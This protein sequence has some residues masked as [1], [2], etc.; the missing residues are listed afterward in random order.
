MNTVPCVLCCDCLCKVFTHADDAPFETS[1]FRACVATGFPSILRIQSDAPSSPSALCVLHLQHLTASSFSLNLPHT[2]HCKWQYLWKIRQRWW[3]RLLSC[4][5]HLQARERGYL[6]IRFSILSVAKRQLV[7][8]GLTL[9]FYLKCNHSVSQNLS[10]YLLCV[11]K[12][13][14]C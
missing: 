9:T 10:L 14:A 2:Y 7:C 5:H 13:F 1:S 3:K 11:C 8:N 12:S 6:W 4:S